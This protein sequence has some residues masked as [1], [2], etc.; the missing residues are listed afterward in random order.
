LL[1]NC[2]VKYAF[3]ACADLNEVPSV[4]HQYSRRASGGIQISRPVGEPVVG[5]ARQRCPDKCLALCQFNAPAGGSPEG[6]T[7]LKRAISW[8]RT[9]RPCQSGIALTLPKA[10]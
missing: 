5:C 2:K 9:W 8:A 4:V 3:A 1:A 7:L 10:A 6:P